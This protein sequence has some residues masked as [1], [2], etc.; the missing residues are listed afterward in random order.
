MFKVIDLDFYACCPDGVFNNLIKNI[1]E[2]RRYNKKSV[3]QMLIDVFI[4][5]AEIKNLF[6]QEN[7]LEQLKNNCIIGKISLNEILS[8]LVCCNEEYGC[9]KIQDVGK[10]LIKIMKR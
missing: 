5:S 3:T 7:E 2:I 6:E 10:R 8:V 9:I 1:N 4:S